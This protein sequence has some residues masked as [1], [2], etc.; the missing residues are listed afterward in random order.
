MQRGGSKRGRRKEDFRTTS[1]RHQDSHRETGHPT[2]QPGGNFLSHFLLPLLP[3]LAKLLQRR[4]R[5]RRREAHPF[6]RKKGGR[7]FGPPPPPP[8]VSPPPQAS[9]GVGPKLK[10]APTRL[11]R[12]LT[13]ADGGLKWAAVAVPPPFVCRPPGL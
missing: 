4:R 13:R 12:S 1:L 5:R 8:P 10:L 6:P 9:E 2:T 11:D 7:N 3:T